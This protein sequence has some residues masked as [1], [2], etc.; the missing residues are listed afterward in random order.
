MKI[1]ELLNSGQSKEVLSWLQGGKP[2]SRTLGEL[3]TT[4]ASIAMAQ[5]LY[6]LGAVRVTAASIVTYDTGDENTGK[7][8]VSLPKDSRVRAQL[9]AWCAEQ[10]HELGFEPENDVGQEHVFLM[11]D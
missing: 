2:G 6:E 5:E 9:F 11:L 7:L 8:I 3:P 1:E 4:T 10:A